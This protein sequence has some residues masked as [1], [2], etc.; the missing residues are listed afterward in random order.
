MFHSL[1][2]VLFLVLVQTECRGLGG[3]GSSG[4]TQRETADRRWTPHPPN[5][6]GR[7]EGNALLT[8]SDPLRSLQLIPLSPLPLRCCQAVWSSSVRSRSGRSTELDCRRSHTSSP[9]FKTFW[10]SICPAMESLRSPNRSVSTHRAA[11]EYL[12]A[13]SRMSLKS[14]ALS[15]TVSE[16]FI[17]K[18]IICSY[19]HS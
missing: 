15:W 6:T 18:D 16:I 12:V 9:A 19:Y 17:Q 4:S 5:R 10:F 3:P 8:G 11:Q 13:Y 2:G 14:P 1:L 7:V